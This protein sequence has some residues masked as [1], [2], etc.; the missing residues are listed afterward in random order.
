MTQESWFRLELLTERPNSVAAE[1]FQAGALGVETQDNDTFEADPIPDGYSRVIAFFEED[2]QA[3]EINTPHN[4]F[5]YQPYND[6]SWRESWKRF[7]RP[8]IISERII[9]GPPWED[10]DAPENGYKI[11]IEPG[12]AFGTGT[13]E[14]TQLCGDILEGLIVSQ[15][16]NEMLDVG[17]GSGILSIA[18]AKLG[19]PKIY[20]IDNDATAVG[21]AI[22]NAKLNLVEASVLSFSTDWEDKKYDLVVA[23]ILAHILL[24]LKS[25]L[26]D[27]VAKNG[28]LVLS[29]ITDTQFEKFLADFVSDDWLVCDIGE[30]G[31][32]RAVVLKAKK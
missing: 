25:K 32:W 29:G 14:T 1:L 13:H 17:C 27:A 23:N 2:A 18:A 19:V 31:E 3:P 4:A 6:L 16:P 28:R 12:M 21:V 22:E 5:V 11:E 9:V 24:S 15:K 7:F 26:Y 8:V 10:F 20:G 30:L